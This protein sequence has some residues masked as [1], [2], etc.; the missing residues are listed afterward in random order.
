MSD[1]TDHPGT[2]EPNRRFQFQLKTVLVLLTL[3]CVFLAVLRS[4]PERAVLV[5]VVLVVALE[6]IYRHRIQ[7]TI[8]EKNYKQFGSILQCIGGAFAGT[9]VGAIVGIVYVVV[10][11]N[12]FSFNPGWL[13]SVKVGAASGCVVG[14]IYPRYAIGLAS[15]VPLP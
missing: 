5:G 10:V 15:I 11:Y 4:W 6:R 13:T 14:L 12:V 3:L 2:S 1:A 9:V 7:D 8:G